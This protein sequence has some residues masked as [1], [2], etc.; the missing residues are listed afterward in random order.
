QLRKGLC[1]RSDLLR[2]IFEFGDENETKIEKKI[3]SSMRIAKVK[4]Y[5][6]RLFSS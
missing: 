2:I 5:V 1:V 4:A 3:P 6:R